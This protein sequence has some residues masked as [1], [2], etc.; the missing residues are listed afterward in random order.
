MEVK[1]VKTFNFSTDI[2]TT[3]YSPL[4]PTPNPPFET[5]L[6]FEHNAWKWNLF[7]HNIA[8]G[9]R[10]RI[11]D[12]L[13][14]DKII[15]SRVLCN[16]YTLRVVSQCPMSFW[17][18]LYVKSIL[19]LSQYSNTFNSEFPLFARPKYSMNT[20]EILLWPGKGFFLHNSRPTAEHKKLIT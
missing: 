11:R 4:P 7:R 6:N 15:Y 8:G 5:M 2:T 1:S 18:P 13:K 12:K 20:K 3:S 17:P 16:N 9:E 14:A 19:S 10:G